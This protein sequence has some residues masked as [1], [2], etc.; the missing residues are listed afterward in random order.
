[1]RKQ[2]LCIVGKKNEYVD[3]SLRLPRYSIAAVNANMISAPIALLG[4]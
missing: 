4:H 1:M 2:G 3:S